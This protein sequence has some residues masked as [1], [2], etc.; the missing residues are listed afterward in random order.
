MNEWYNDDSFWITWAPYLFSA[1]RVTR[2][3][4]DVSNV[5]E[6]LTLQAGARILDLCCGTGRHALELSRRGYAVTGIDRT[7]SYLQSARALARN[8]HL[9][10]D[11]LRADARALDI[12]NRFDAAISMFTSF[13]YYSDPRDD[14]RVASGLYKALKPGGGLVVE[15]EGKEVIARDFREREWFWHEDGTIG[16]H[17]RAVRGGWDSIESRWILL[18]D[19]AVAWE[20]T[21]SHRL[22]SGVE[23]RD[24]LGRAAFSKVEVYGSLAGDPYD[25][26]AQGLVAV[27]TK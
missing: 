21:I 11:F 4:Q 5:I 1:D 10:V 27:A 15:T 16:L 24:V 17:E 19:G 8:E 12:R 7:D 6:L 9:K 3:Q 26:R 13:S 25:H 2:T 23:L 18:R 20:G 22:Y 14:L